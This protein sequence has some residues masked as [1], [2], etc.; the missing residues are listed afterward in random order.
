M[1]TPQEFI[2]NFMSVL[3]ATSL[4]GFEAMDEAVRQTTNFS[5]WQAVVDS[6]YRDCSNY[7]GNGDAFLKEKCG[8]ILKNVDTG[9]ITGA[10]AGGGV[11]KTAESVVP[12]DTAEWLMPTNSSTTYDAFGLTVNWPDLGTLNEAQL[13][14]VSGLYT[15]WIPQSL[16]LI[17]NSYGFT[18]N[19]AGTMVN[20]ISKVNFEYKNSNT[21]AYVTHT[22]DRTGKTTSL[23]LTINMKYYGD[24]S[25]TDV[26]G[27]SG[28]GFLLDR[29]IAHEM[30]HAAMAANIN[31]FAKLP[32]YF[33][34][35]AAEL[36]HGIDDDRYYSISY[37]ANNPDYLYKVLNNRN[38]RLRY[39]EEEYSGGYMVLRYLA[40]QSSEYPTDVVTAP[41][42]PEPEPPSRSTPV[43]E[44]ASDDTV[45]KVT[46]SGA[47]W[48]SGFDPTTG[49]RVG[50]Y[51]KAVTADASS[52]SGDIIL[53]G[54]A[55]GNLLKGGKG[56][57]SL[58]GGGAS[59]D[60]L[61]GG[62]GQDVFWFGG[63][64]GHDVVQSFASGYQGDVL[65]FYSGSLTGI[66][67]SGNAVTLSMADG[68]SLKVNTNAGADGV[69]LYSTD[70]GNRTFEAKIGESSKANVLSYNEDLSFCQGGKGKDTL[71]VTGSGGNF[72][73]LDGSRGQGF[74][75]FEVVDGSKSSG[76]D[77]L[78]GS[79]AEELIMGGSGEASLWGG[80][81]SGNDTLQAG[82]GANVLF[83]GYG[84]GN[85]VIQ[86]T[87]SS[88]RVMLYN[89]GLEHISGAEIDASSVKISTTAGQT[90]TVLGE[91]RFTLADGSTWQADHKTKQWS[92]G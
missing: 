5:S 8:I 4:K 83:Y 34:E 91:A 56:Q 39:S 36:V 52:A 57:T 27:K 6:I 24:M 42:N 40:Y 9:A 38:D 70:G 73:W 62:T 10:D 37:L 84:E 66:S 44:D 3:D 68:S 58:W 49:R 61:Q 20:T 7:G 21:L 18:F 16:E 17:K 11:V 85:D 26:N 47:Y 31:N 48:L 41:E 23:E 60:T 78:A 81:G 86:K 82:S 45:V 92:S 87:T 63:G 79:G 77:Q 15:W 67:R 72:V 55:N 29:V 19:E 25:G 90:L 46:E 88:D 1:A 53:A 76:A 2:R 30:T 14:M 80:A 35:G 22:Y 43:P 59:S 54:N 32:H 51:P 28:E 69:I 13:R 33:K 64:D 12:E 71:Q 65:N 89:M 75:D 50:A 74:V